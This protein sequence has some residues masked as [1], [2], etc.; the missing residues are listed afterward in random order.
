MVISEDGPTVLANGHGPALDVRLGCR[1]QPGQ[2]VGSRLRGNR[3]ST[4]GDFQAVPVHEFPLEP[5]LEKFGV[6]TYRNNEV[7]LCLSQSVKRP[8]AY[9]QEIELYRQED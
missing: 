9:R 3:Y 1:L 4:R 7:A 6:S 2:Q 5:P 8:A